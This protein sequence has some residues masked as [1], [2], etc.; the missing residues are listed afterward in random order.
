VSGGRLTKV[1]TNL[2]PGLRDLRAPLA[3]GYLWLITVWLALKHA[4]WLPAKRPPGNGEVAQLWSLGGALGKTVL[5]AALSFLAYL[6]GSFLEMSPEG[7]IA[8][9]YGPVSTLTATPWYLRYLW[10]LNIRGDL[11]THFGGYSAPVM[12]VAYSVSQQARWDLLKLL[13][14]RNAISS[15]AHDE[16]VRWDTSK[17]PPTISEAVD[18]LAKS[19]AK[20]V[21]SGEFS[22]MKP[23]CIWRE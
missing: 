20:K 2:L 9:R 3:S 17:E 22:E 6:V 15:G 7:R 19:S 14:E 4:G 12:R 11:S 10:Y 21:R 13:Q 5:L 1:L 18:R 8:A 23:N 16:L